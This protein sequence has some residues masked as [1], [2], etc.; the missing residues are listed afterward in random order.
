MVAK[1]GTKRAAVSDAEDT[2]KKMHLAAVMEG[3]MDSKHM[4]DSVRDMIRASLPACIAPAPEDRHEA[5]SMVLEWAGETLQSVEHH[6]QEE[7]NAEQ[8]A[9]A[10]ADAIKEK[11]QQS[12]VDAS[13]RQTDAIEAVKSKT[14]AVADFTKAVEVAEAAAAELAAALAAGEAST[15]QTRRTKEQVETI[16]EKDVKA[17]V[18]G[19]AGAHYKNCL[20][21]VEILGLDDSL[22]TAL[23]SAC[24]KIPSDRG[25]FDTMIVQ[26]LEASF[27]N[28]LASL[29]TALADEEVVQQDR[30]AAMEDAKKCLVESKLV[31]RRAQDVLSAAQSKEREAIDGARAAH[32]A[33][34]HYGP[35]HKRTTASRD[36]RAGALRHFQ[37]YNMRSFQMLRD[38]ITELSPDPDTQTTEAPSVE[39]KV[40]EPGT[41]PA[42]VVGGA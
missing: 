36:A 23:P 4:P 8:A 6:M 12:V 16:M 14:A 37:E 38:G 31:L 21:V 27:A 28:K 39:K 15:V 3:I 1:R 41:S 17:I 35:E 9:V 25:P 22:L 2:P 24:A 20:Q 18:D 5:Q 7:L 29:T 30:V 11:V 19:K 34:D 13:I 42:V 33:M 26:Q 10:T 32:A 40:L